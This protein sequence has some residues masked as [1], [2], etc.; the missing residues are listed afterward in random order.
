MSRD[1][2]ALLKAE[3][4]NFFPL[5]GSAKSDKS[6]L[7]LL[8]PAQMKGENTFGTFGTSLSTEKKP[9]F[10]Q[11]DI[12]TSPMTEGEKEAFEERAAILEFDGGLSREEAEKVAAQQQETATSTIEDCQQDRE[13]WAYF[14]GHVAELPKPGQ[15]RTCEHLRKPGLSD[16][17]CARREDLPLAYGEHHPLRQCPADGGA[18][19][20]EWRDSNGRSKHACQAED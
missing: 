11:E 16:G 20:Q 12:P 19:C 5:D 3:K 2:I 9:L 17:Y 8:A 6:L 1:Y 4:A 10:Q 18:S 15:C 13:A 14:L 7:A